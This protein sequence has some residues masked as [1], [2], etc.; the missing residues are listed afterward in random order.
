[1]I[2]HKFLITVLGIITT[3]LL[4]NPTYA[5]DAADLYK[6][7]TCIAC[8]GIEGRL[9]VM[10]IYPRIA[11]QNASY[12]L[13]QMKDIKSGSRSNAHTAAMKNVMHLINDEE[14]SVLAEWLANLP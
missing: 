13:A 9:P 10:D 11:G 12:M 3:V 7:R 6:E 1:M 14:M 4:S 2:T 5:L 8:H